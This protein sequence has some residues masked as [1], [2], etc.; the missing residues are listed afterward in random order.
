[1]PR[2]TP[3]EPATGEA[4]ELLDAVQAALGV[5]P[6]MT[7]TMARN[8]AVLKGWME[9]NGALGKTLTRALNEQIALAVA[10]ENGCGYCLSAHTAIGGRIGVSE[11][12][13]RAS[14]RERV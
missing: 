1:M 5:T 9:L 2:L 10:E 8:P 3:V 13:G 11:K 7:R 12:I 14:C 4:K 6:N